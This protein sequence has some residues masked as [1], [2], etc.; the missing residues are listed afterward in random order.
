MANL[1]STDRAGGVVTVTLQ[2]PQKRNALSIDLRIELADTLNALSEDED[3]A[4][5]ILTGA[6]SAFCA[7]M[8]LTQMGGDAEHKKRL[9][10][11]ST[12]VFE[13]VASCTRPLLAAVNGPALAG[14]FALAMLCDLRI[15]SPTA[16]YGFPELPIGIPP[17]YA[18]VRNVLGPAQAAEISLTGR[19]FGAVEALSL[20]VVNEVTDGERALERTVEISEAIA[21]APMAATLETK[22]RILTDRRATLGPMLEDEARVFR[23][24]LGVS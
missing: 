4:V 10:E 18:S 12:G 24:A 8:D 21:T 16:T 13:A 19:T 1:V 22:R 15:S 2:R 9:V 6:G 3:V 7:G 5:V 20:G 23:E 17:S 11:T 14:G